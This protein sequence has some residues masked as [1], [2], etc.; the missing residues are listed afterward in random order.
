M[1]PLNLNRRI[2][3]SLLTTFVATSAQGALTD[4]AN[5]PLNPYSAQA[6]VLPNLMFTLDDSGSMAWDYLPDDVASAQGNTS[7]NC[8]GWGGSGAGSETRT[9]CNASLR[10]APHYASQYNKIYYDPNVT[11]S[12]GVDPDASV[13][14]A[15]DSRL[16]QDNMSAVRED[17]YG[18]SSTINLTNGYPEV[19]Y[20][21]NTNDLATDTVNCKGN[22]PNYIYP[23]ATYRHKKV[24]YG[25]PFYYT[26]TPR[27]YCDNERLVN[28]IWSTSPSGSYVF[29]APVRH[30]QTEAIA[31][32]GSV[33][34]GNTGGKP[35]CQLKYGTDHTYV[36]YGTF[37]RTNITTNLF[38]STT[39]G[40]RPNR[41]DCAA[42]P[43]C[44]ATE[45]AINFANWYAYYRTRMQMMK[46][47]VGQAFIPIDGR[48][49]VGF[50]T[51]NPGSPVTNNKFLPVDKFDISHKTAWYNKLYSQTPN[52]GT[53]LREALSRVGRYFGGKSSGINAGMTPDPVQYSCQRHYNILTTDG[54]WNGNAGIDLSGGYIGNED[55]VDAGYTQRTDGAY[56]PNPVPAGINNVSQ[57]YNSLADIA[58]YFYKTDLRPAGSVG[59]LGI[60]VDNNN[61]KAILGKDENTAQHMVTYT[62]GLVD[63]KMTY[64][65][66]YDTNNNAV[67]PT[68]Y[69]R[70]KN[71]L[72]GCSW[73]SSN[74]VCNWPMPVAN[75]D[76]ALDDLWHAAVN[77]YGKY[78]NAK[79][80]EDL[81]SGLQSIFDSID[82]QDGAAAAAATS[83]PNIT[84]DDRDIFSTVYKPL[85]W[86]GEVTKQEIDVGNGNVIST[87]VWKA[88]ALLDALVTASTDGRTIY[89]FD[90][91]PTAAASKLKAFNWSLLS[92]AERNHFSSKGALLHQYPSLSSANQANA[93]DGEKL[94]NYLR[95][96]WEY[97]L[98]SGNLNGAFRERKHVL[99][100]TVSATP[101][102]VRA[103]RFGFSDSGYGAFK[104]THTPDLTVNP[105]TTGRAPMLYVA[106]NDGMLH[107]FDASTGGSNSGKELWAFAPRSLFPKLHK[108]A[109]DDYDVNHRFYVDGSPEV[110]DVKIGG[111]WKTVLV[112]GMNAGGRA[113]Y[114]L[115]VTDPANPAALWEFCTDSSLCSAHDDDLGLTFGN[116]VITKDH[117]GNWVV[118]VASGYNNVSPGDG[119][120]Y[121]YV[122]DVATGNILRKMSTGSGSVGSPSGLAKIAGWADDGN[123]DNTAKYVYGA[124]LNGDVWRFDMTASPLSPNPLKLATLTNASG[125]PQPVTTKPELGLCNYKKM[126]L[127]GT[128]KYMGSSDASN[129][130]QNTVY[131]FKDELLATGLGTL[132]TS[133]QM[134][135]QTITADVSDPNKRTVTTNP[136]NLSSGF[137]WYADLITSGE[138]VNVDPQLVLGTL[139]VAGN[140]PDSSADVCDLAGA[141][142]QYQFDYCTGS[143]VDAS[144]GVVATK[145]GA[146]TAGFVVISLPDGT[147]KQIVTDRTGAQSTMAVNIGGGGAGAR[148]VGWREILN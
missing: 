88:Q 61:V 125:N 60:S 100:D 21:K 99:G 9:S 111:V 22:S 128:G 109:T 6:T 137:G 64:V 135:Q 23:D 123:V 101:V 4:I 105:P 148:R 97:E 17:A 62:I 91:S 103:P 20:C 138:R 31:V 139:L 106:A 86:T 13:V 113:Y 24:R 136:V 59:V 95:G 83:S 43:V 7:R 80:K 36:R 82:S 108:L 77:G 140:I 118:I 114:A 112:G 147:I 27:E 116:P 141:S 58:A 32:S 14:G 28:C 115:D 50:V 53:P 19:V 73:Q 70:I 85:D 104:A 46:T 94:I 144:G 127:I 98:R 145:M 49:R 72:T 68:D 16:P 44:N 119:K 146:M 84:Q 132:R 2:I 79:N 89:T 133:G 34:T 120:G 25:E 37:V 78:F 41:T 26:I 35:R 87:P 96:R 134:V 3:A 51:I 81:A 47:A 39:Y 38:S 131:G 117:A 1:S 121:L 92:T 10:E 110:M 143:F 76:T 71:G 93:N 63:G 45:E 65:S 33:V 55:N 11:Y 69:Y 30:C 75:T 42:K 15:A 107:A 129:T 48:F 67:I 57:G 40:N 142:W 18:S 12:P 130:S 102:Y 124:D 5:E 29:P 90:S 74:S 54:Y 66:D 52:G 56:D 8:R 122:L 126:V